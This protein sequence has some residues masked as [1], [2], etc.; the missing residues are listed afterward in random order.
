[1][2]FIFLKLVY[3][4]EVYEKYFSFVFL[5]IGGEG[6]ILGVGVDVVL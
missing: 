1:M 5:G 3:F 4:L 6:V 2:S